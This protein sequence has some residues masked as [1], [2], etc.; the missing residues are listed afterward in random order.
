M[1]TL[2]QEP[3]LSHIEPYGPSGAAVKL[4]CDLSGGGYDIKRLT[5]VDHLKHQY[6]L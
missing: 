5:G 6:R 2:G 4:C 3:L 1:T